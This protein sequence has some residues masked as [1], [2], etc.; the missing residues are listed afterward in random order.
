MA[1]RLRITPNRN[2]YAKGPKID[3]QNIKTNKIP[4][5]IK[6]QANR[7]LFHNTDAM[8]FESNFYS[9]VSINTEWQNGFNIVKKF[10]CF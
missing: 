8:N 1:Q 5:K 6:E 3:H 2:K 7:N 4:F 9:S 10:A